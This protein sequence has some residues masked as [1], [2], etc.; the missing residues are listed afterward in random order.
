MIAASTDLR[1]GI[2]SLQ[3]FMDRFRKD[4]LTEATF[5]GGA[6]KLIPGFPELTEIVQQC[7]VPEFW[8]R[9][10]GLKTLVRIILEQQV[11]LLSA[12]AAWDEEG[13]RENPLIRILFPLGFSGDREPLGS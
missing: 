9:A 12:K 10:E 3:L 13:H 11:S 6:A 5:S 4:D 8:S 1:D 7:G 2:S